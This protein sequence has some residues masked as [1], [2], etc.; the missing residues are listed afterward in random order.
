MKRISNQL[1]PEESSLD[2]PV[3]LIF[4]WTSETTPNEVTV[5]ELDEID[6]LRQMILETTDEAPVFLTST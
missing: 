6:K 2:A 1:R 4:D 5:E 3:Y